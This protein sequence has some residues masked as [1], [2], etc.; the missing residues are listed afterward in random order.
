MTSTITLLL[1]DLIVFYLTGPS[2]MIPYQYKC[3]MFIDNRKFYK[4]IRKYAFLCNGN[5]KRIHV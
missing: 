3:Y 2:T 5:T 4:Y 1:S